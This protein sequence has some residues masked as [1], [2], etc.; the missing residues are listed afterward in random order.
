M[1]ITVEVS[2]SFVRCMKRYLQEVD[3]IE[4]PLK[5]DIQKEIYHLVDT[6]YQGHPNFEE[7]TT[8]K[9]SLGYI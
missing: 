6:N 3:G 5:K 7:Y 1:K 4:R 2:D 9:N 8:D